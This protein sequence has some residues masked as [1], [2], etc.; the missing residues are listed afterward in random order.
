AS[1]DRVT[2]SCAASSGPRQALYG[3]RQACATTRDRA[4]TERTMSTSALSVRGWGPRPD[5]GVYAALFLVSAGLLTLEVS[6]TRFFSFTVWY[7]LAYLTIIL[8]L[9]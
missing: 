3:A 9:L 5:R 2:D 1:C 6:L 4:M 8:A 7:H